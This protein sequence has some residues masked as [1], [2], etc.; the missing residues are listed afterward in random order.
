MRTLIVSLITLAVGITVG[1]HASDRE[2]EEEMMRTRNRMLVELKNTNER[3]AECKKLQV[4]TM[5][6]ALSLSEDRTINKLVYR[7]IQEDYE[8]RNSR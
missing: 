3:L 8:K 6:L 1:Y 5:F 7:K 4:K 2:C